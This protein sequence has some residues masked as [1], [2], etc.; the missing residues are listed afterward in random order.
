[1]TKKK[2]WEASQERRSEKARLRQL[3]MFN[4]LSKFIM[5]WRLNGGTKKYPPEGDMA[6]WLNERGWRSER[7]G[8][9]TFRTVQEMLHFMDPDQQA[10]P[11]AGKERLARIDGEFLSGTETMFVGYSPEFWMEYRDAVIA[12]WKPSHLKSDEGDL[13]CED[14]DTLG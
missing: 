6:K 9:I 12:G 11:E 2:G 3:G 7:G 13:G 4:D 14:E 5:D 8:E 1:M 10:L